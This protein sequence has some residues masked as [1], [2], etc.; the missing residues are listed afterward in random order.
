MDDALRATMEEEWRDVSAR[1][2]AMMERLPSMQEKYK[3]LERANRARAVKETEKAAREKTAQMERVLARSQLNHS[4]LEA[5]RTGGDKEKF[6]QYEQI[7]HEDEKQFYLEQARVKD[8]CRAY[9][10]EITRQGFSCEQSYLEA[11]LTKSAQAALAREVEPFREEYAR[12]YERCAQ[13][14]A[15]LDA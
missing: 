12:L 14:S 3:K 1:L 7:C 15:A 13:L 5:A 2:Q 4:L 6:A 10:D 9:R 8:A 11:F